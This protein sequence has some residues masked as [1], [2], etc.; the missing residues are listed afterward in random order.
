M[1]EE[2]ANEVNTDENTEDSTGAT[3]VATEEE[4]NEAAESKEL[5][6]FDFG[7]FQAGLEDI[8]KWK[9]AFETKKSKDADYTQKTQSLADQRKQLDEKLKLANQRL[10]E[11]GQLESEIDILSMGDLAKVDLDKVLEEE[12]TEEYLR[13]ERE[14]GKSKAKKAAILQKIKKAQESSLIDAQK[15]LKDMLDWSDTKK[16]SQDVSDINKYVNAS[17]M[18]LNEFNKVNSPH[19]MQAFLEAQKYRDLLSKRESTTKK[20]INAPK[21]ARPSPKGGNAPLTLA[22]RLYGKN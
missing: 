7:E 5:E 15:Q 22:Q 21:I 10:D 9:N 18:P 17:G 20:V 4:S 16:Q 11:I 13:Y 8:S 2:L 12:G 3:E 6:V 1:S 19:V 14:I